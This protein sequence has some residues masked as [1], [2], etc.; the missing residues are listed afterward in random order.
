MCLRALAG[1]ARIADRHSPGAHPAL[2][3]GRGS[4]GSSARSTSLLRPARRCVKRG[5][6]CPAL[7]SEAAEQQQRMAAV[8]DPAGRISIEAVSALA[9]PSRPSER[10]EQ[11]GADLLPQVE[12]T[13]RDRAGRGAAGAP[14]NQVPNQPGDADGMRGHQRVRS[15]VRDDEQSGREQPR[16]P[17]AKTCPCQRGPLES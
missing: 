13:V 14:A 10:D 6:R 9:A 4:K 17:I 16:S 12:Q 2:S 1:A 11:D 3:Q 8:A 5:V 7:R 15:N